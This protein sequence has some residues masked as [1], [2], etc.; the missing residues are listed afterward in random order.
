[1]VRRRTRDPAALPESEW[2]DVGIYRHQPSG[3]ATHVSRGDAHAADIIAGRYPL[4]Q[5]RQDEQRRRALVQQL[6]G[7]GP[8]AC[9]VL[10]R[11]TGED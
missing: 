2:A 1:M 9:D 8:T 4:E 10:R 6:R 3:I 5:A 7:R 11:Y